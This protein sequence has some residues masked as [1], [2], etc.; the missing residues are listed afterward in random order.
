MNVKPRA[1]TGGVIT[2]ALLL[3]VLSAGLYAFSWNRESAGFLS[4]DAVYLL[5][6]DSFSP[7]RPADPGLTA[8]VMR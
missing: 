3:L 1:L 2:A 6:A 7:F 4:D 8:Y 5:M